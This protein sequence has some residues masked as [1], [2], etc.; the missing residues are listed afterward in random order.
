MLWR[1]RYILLFVMLV[2]TRMNSNKLSA[3]SKGTV[4]F[5]HSIK[6]GRSVNFSLK[7]SLAIISYIV[8]VKNSFDSAL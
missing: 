6:I 5:Y 3:F 8:I 2:C 1:G 7:V 4:S